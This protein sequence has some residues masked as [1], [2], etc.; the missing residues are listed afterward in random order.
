MNKEEMTTQ[1][2]I[3]RLTTQPD[4]VLVEELLI[5]KINDLLDFRFSGDDSTEV[6]A[7]NVVASKMAIE[8][9]QSFLYEVEIIKRE[10][11]KNSIK[12]YI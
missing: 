4:W 5:S 8:V 6:I 3:K 10:L 12:K 2:R 11:P 9:L 1:D 7:R